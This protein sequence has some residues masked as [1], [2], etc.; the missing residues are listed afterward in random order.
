MA[1]WYTRD[2]IIM[3]KRLNVI[4]RL[5][6]L[7]WKLVFE[8]VLVIIFIGYGIHHWEEIRTIIQQFSLLTLC[9]C[10]AFYSLSHFFAAGAAKALF[11]ANG[12]SLSYR[13]FLNIHIQRLPAKYVPGGIWQTIGR[14]SDLI[15][16]KIPIN[17]V[18]KIL[19]LEQLLA[20]WWAGVLGFFLVLL[21]FGSDVSLIALIILLA[22]L[23]AAGATTLFLSVKKPSLALLI[24][25]ARSPRVSIYYIGG[26]CCLAVAFT[27]YALHTGIM[28]NNPL[29]ISASYLVSWMLGAIAFF[30]PQG[31]GIFELAMQRLALH[32]QGATETLWLI[33]SYRLIVLS[34]DLILWAAHGIRYRIKSPHPV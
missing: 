33:G 23:L 6:L 30:A 9:V 24:K 1:I 11:R 7:Y 5:A 32:T 28:Q 21:T 4:L 8:S 12:Y 18:V 19:F 17:V 15:Q 25:A 34:S 31:M 13:F 27:C 20:I 10:I 16:Q 14:G 26:W 29:Q 22:L 3:T 2:K